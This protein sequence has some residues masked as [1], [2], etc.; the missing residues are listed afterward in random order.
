[1]ASCLT[2]VE[3]ARIRVEI[4]VIDNASVDGNPKRV[5]D[6]SPMVRLIR[7]EENLGFSAA[8]NKA[9]R[10]SRGASVLILNDDAILQEGSLGAMLQSLYSSREV[11]AVG[12]RLLNPDGSPQR[13]FTNRRFP[14][15]RSLVV[16]LFGLNPLFE[17]NAFTRD[18]L[19]HSRDPE[20]SGEADHLAGAC[21]LLRREA[22]EAVGDF[23]ERYY[24]F[25][26]DADLCY[27]LKQGNWRILYLAEALVTHYGSAS[28]KRLMRSERN[29]IYFRS[30]TL[31]FRQHSN[32]ATYLLVRIG[33]VMA[34]ALQAVVSTLTGSDAGARSVCPPERT[35]GGSVGRPQ[36]KEGQEF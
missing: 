28:F 26:E 27:R 8:N 2:E 12:P 36:I 22:L 11:G 29:S 6:L 18:L 7:N 34:M 21:L 16:S 32:S 33:S 1:V 30:L 31:Y 17:R 3:R 9:I 14:R 20:R 4:I 13:G 23:D 24:Y 35:P 19:T 10:L 15:L 25:C 5:A